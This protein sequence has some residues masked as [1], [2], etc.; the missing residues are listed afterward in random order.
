R[1]LSELRGE[2]EEAK[3]LG[4]VERA[5]HAE[6]EI[7]ALTQ[8]LA[9]A[10]GLGGRT[11]RAASA[12]ERA[13]Q[14]I[15]KSIK[16]ALETI[17]QSEPRRGTLLAR[18]IKTGTFCSYQPDP[19]VP[20]AWEFAKPLTQP[21]E[22]PTASSDPVVVQVDRGQPLPVVLEA[23]PFSL[24]ERTAFVG[25]ETECGVMRALIDRALNGQGSVVL[26]GGGPG[27]GKSR[28]AL[29]MMEYA[30]RVGFQCLVGHCYEQD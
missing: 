26:L 14:S 19:E 1:R 23:S 29:E 24:A 6:E 8:E 21:A 16:S 3:E 20:L 4:H 13:R 7:A 9:R 22:H 30:A 2:V 28:L 5:E 17:T 25:R 18:C 12:A 15:T 27:V 10:V 11:R